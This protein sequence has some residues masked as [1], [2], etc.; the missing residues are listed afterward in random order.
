MNV[1]QELL[2][3]QIECAEQQEKI[4]ELEERLDKLSGRVTHNEAW[5]RPLA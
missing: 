2:E 4:V 5:F 1:E 3:L